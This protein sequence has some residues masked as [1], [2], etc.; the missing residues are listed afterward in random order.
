VYRYATGGAVDE[1]FDRWDEGREDVVD[2]ETVILLDN[3]GSM[4]WTIESA[5][6][7]MWAIKRALDKVN[8]STTVLTF[9]NKSS[10]LYSADERAT[11]KLKYAGSEGSTEPL[12]ALRYARS[13]LANSKRAIKIV[14]S[15]TDGYW[16]GGDECDETLKYLR[17]AGVL[18]ALAYVSNPDHYR[19]GETTTIDTHG[20]AVAVNVT[21]GKDLFTLARQMVKVG[22]AHNLAS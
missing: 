6:D 9:G 3:S 21:N 12:K 20:C 8:A 17:K 2:I 19:P 22:V 13:L 16:W 10:L 11:T 1:V 14:I 18:T 5:H 15:I 7:S 4:S